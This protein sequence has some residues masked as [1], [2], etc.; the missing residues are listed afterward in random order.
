MEKYLNRSVNP[1][2]K[3]SNEKQATKRKYKEEY[4]EFG[5]ISSGSEDSPLPVCLICNTTLSNQS[6]VPNKLKRHLD[7]NHSSIK[8]KPKEYFEHLSTQHVKQAKKAQGIH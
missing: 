5:F 8:D 4:L 1:K 3:I 2:K 7:L 6:L